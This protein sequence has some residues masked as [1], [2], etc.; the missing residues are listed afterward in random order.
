M[1]DIGNSVRR[2]ARSS[3]QLLPGQF[4][5]KVLLAARD[6]TSIAIGV[7]K[8]ACVS[9]LFAAEFGQQIEVLTVGAEKNVAG[10]RAESAKALG[11]IGSHVRIERVV[12]EV[13]SGGDVGSANDDDIERLAGFLCRHGPRR[14]ALRV[15]GGFVGGER[16]VGQR[17]LFAVVQGAVDFGC[18][19][20]EFRAASVLE[21]GF[22]T[23]FD[24][25]NV[26]VHHHVRCRRV[27]SG[28]ELQEFAAAGAVVVMGVA[29]KQD[30][31]LRHQEAELL[32][33]QAY[34]GRRSGQIAVDEDVSS[35]R[36]DQI[37][38]QIAASDIVQIA[39][40]AKG[41]Q[42][43]RPFRVYSGTQGSWQGIGRGCGEEG[44]N[45][46]PVQ[47]GGGVVARR[48][49]GLPEVQYRKGRGCGFPV[50]CD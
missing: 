43:R 17:D 22:A 44:E 8:C 26:G 19:K 33:A 20:K 10:E 3:S 49:D 9:G 24:H 35:G 28:G 48:H 50:C 27:G 32:N 13:V 29:D 4:G 15:A 14:A 18:W 21:I 7:H 11:E 34:L 23:G 41:R 25:G 40:N 47:I 30:L 45:E 42:G 37:A 46:S 5:L 2:V 16:G 6:E 36:G 38:G 12:N 39:G 1:W 31:D